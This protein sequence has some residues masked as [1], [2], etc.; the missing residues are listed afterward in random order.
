M[1]DGVNPDFDKVAAGPPP[2]FGFDWK[3][4][5]LRMERAAYYAYYAYTLDAKPP[6]CSWEQLPEKERARWRQ[7]ADA[8][9]LSTQGDVALL[10][11]ELDGAPVA[12]P[13]PREDWDHRPARVMG[14]FN[15]EVV[16]LGPDVKLGPG[17]LPDLAADEP[18]TREGKADGK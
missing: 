5:R 4:E 2:V 1:A 12:V 10:L 7:V 17:L 13:I 11:G 14:V 6:P 8:V 15:G 16:K 18:H 3:A 9:R